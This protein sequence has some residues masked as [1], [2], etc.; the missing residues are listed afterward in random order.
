[1]K[2]YK[3][4]RKELADTTGPT[5]GAPGPCSVCKAMTPHETLCNF[6]ARCGRCF[7]AYCKAAFDDEANAARY[8][9]G[10]SRS[11]AAR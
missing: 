9:D 5:E 4:I 2:S 10:L 7:T 1:M 8:R 11:R 3:D 6:G